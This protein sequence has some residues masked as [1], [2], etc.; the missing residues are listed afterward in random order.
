[1][2][3]VS[4]CAAA[5][6]PPADAAAGLTRGRRATP[7]GLAEGVLCLERGAKRVCSKSGIEEG[8]GRALLER[9]G[10]RGGRCRPELGVG[11]GRRDGLSEVDAEGRARGRGGRGAYGKPRRREVGVGSNPRKR[12]GGGAPKRRSYTK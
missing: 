9:V 2:S 10:I 5:V 11:L 4:Q 8:R 3:K 7:K 1:M 6:Q 12:E